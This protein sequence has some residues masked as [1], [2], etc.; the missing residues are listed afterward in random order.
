[1]SRDK[2]LRAVLPRLGSEAAGERIA[3][4]AALERLLP[5]GQT[6]REVIEVGLFYLDRRGVDASPIEE[7]GRLRSAAQAATRR[8]E[9]QRGRIAALEAAIRD[10]LAQLRQARD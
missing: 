4:L 8:D 2:R 6:L 3:A 1:M 7:V 10:A 5:A 9:Q